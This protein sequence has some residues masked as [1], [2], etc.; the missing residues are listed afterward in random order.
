[1]TTTTTTAPAPGKIW[2]VGAIV[3]DRA[4]G[5]VY[6]VAAKPV[7][8]HE[9]AAPVYRLTKAKAETI[10]A[11][12][13]SGRRLADLIC[14]IQRYGNHTPGSR[15]GDPS[16]RA[17]VPD[18]LTRERFERPKRD[19]NSYADMPS[20]TLREIDYGR[21]VAIAVTPIYDDAPI[22]A[23]RDLTPA[24]RASVRA[25]IETAKQGAWLPQVVVEHEETKKNADPKN[26]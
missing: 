16:R 2:K 20:L 21:L 5:D 15:G 8:Y 17:P 3:A 6:R 7:R 18:G 23:W 12:Y 10:P 25:D 11:G 13:A 24:E 19:P 4:T 9:D 14:A 26:L 1:M 22:V